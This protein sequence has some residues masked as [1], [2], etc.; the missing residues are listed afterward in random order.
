M[1]VLEALASECQR[2]LNVREHFLCP[3]KGFILLGH[4]WDKV[5]IAELCKQQM[6][7]W[8]PHSYKTSVVD[9]CDAAS[10]GLAKAHVAKALETNANG[11][12]P[13]S[14]DYL[15]QFRGSID[16]VGPTSFWG[17]MSDLTDPDRE[18]ETVEIGY[19]K[20]NID[21]KPVYCGDVLAN[22]HFELL[23]DR[24]ANA[25]VRI[26]PGPLLTNT[27]V[28]TVVSYWTAGAMVYGAGILPNV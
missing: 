14:S 7:V 9:L 22:M 27:D 8:T 18:D 23:I 2:D 10:I 3:P 1:S 4:T 15:Q 13:F 12:T 28:V 16:E 25:N 5:A 24:F 6:Y 19:D 17:V 20:A 26:L 21:G 11:F